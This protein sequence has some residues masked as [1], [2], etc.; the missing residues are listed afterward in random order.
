MTGRIFTLRGKIL[1][2]SA[3]KGM[4]MM[5]KPNYYYY[6]YFRVFTA[7]AATA[8]FALVLTV[9]ASNGTATAQTV[10]P[11]T[12][13]VDNADSS[14]FYA[15]VGTWSTGDTNKI[16]DSLSKAY[17]SDQSYRYTRPKVSSYYAWYKVSMP[18]AGQYDVYAWW[19]KLDSNNDQTVF[20]VWTKNGWVKAPTQKQRENGGQWRHLGEYT[21]NAEDDWDI[22]VDYRSSGTGNIIADAVKI[23]KKA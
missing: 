13:I 7:L 18:T 16:S 3:I 22:S 1:T 21:M 20:W 10:S 6:Y 11:Y 12:Q 15:K 8:L 9:L 19:P 4:R 5:A 14:R 23:V 17:G 2:S